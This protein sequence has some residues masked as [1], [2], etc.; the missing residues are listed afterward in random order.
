MMKTS[1]ERK[2]FYH[3]RSP[4]SNTS[5]YSTFTHEYCNHALHNPNIIANHL[6]TI[7]FA[8]ARGTTYV[9]SLL[10]SVMI[11]KTITEAALF[12]IDGTRI[13]FKA[14]TGSIENTAQ[15]SGQDTFC[16][17]FS[18]MIGSPLSLVKRLKA[19]SPNIAWTELK[20]ESYMQ[21]SAIPFSSLTTLAFFQLE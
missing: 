12:S 18:K 16:I 17:A 1:H 5:L 3:R 13:K 7:P 19:H 4:R 8:Q 21:Y 14:W 2:G 6:E 10:S 11:E 9:A 20:R 15:I